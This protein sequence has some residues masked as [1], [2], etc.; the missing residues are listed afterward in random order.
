MKVLLCVGSI[1][2]RK[3]QLDII[4]AIGNYLKDL[5][6]VLLLIGDGDQRSR[7]AE[8]AIAHGIADRIIFE[9]YKEN[10]FDYYSISD[11]FILASS[12][13]GLPGVVMEAMYFSLP[14]IVSDI[15]NNKEI[16]IDKSNGLLFKMGDEKSLADAIRLIVSDS[17][18]SSNIALN[19][20]RDFQ[21]KYE[22]SIM[23]SKLM[24][25]ITTIQH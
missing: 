15:E 25:L 20:K 23:L 3:R 7:C 12:A 24:E 2:S 5:P 16:V 10:V 18:L 4:N 13:E 14:V 19:G 11:M 21:E 9:G 22:F 6:I 8:A 17:T 1:D